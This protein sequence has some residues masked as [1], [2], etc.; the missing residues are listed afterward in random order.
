MYEFVDR[1]ALVMPAFLLTFTR[2]SGLLATLPILSYP[3]ITNKYRI[4]MALMMSL[5]LFP[6]IE[7]TSLEITTNSALFLALGKELIIGMMLGLGTRILFESLNW[8]GGFIGRQ[9]GIA[10]ANVMDP[11]SQGQIPLVSQFWLLVV[12]AYFFCGQWASDAVF[13][14]LSKF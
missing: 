13:H 12:V 5:V 2:L 10:M 3:M 8:A 7:T 14:T 6:V 9:M 11:T 4:A 1:I